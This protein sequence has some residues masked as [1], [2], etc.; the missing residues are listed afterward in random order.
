MTGTYFHFV[1]SKTESMALGQQTFKGKRHTEQDTGQ[2]GEHTSIL[3][4]SEDYK[5]KWWIVE[6]LSGA[7]N[8]HNHWGTMACFIVREILGLSFLSD[9]DFPVNRSSLMVLFLDMR[10]KELYT[11]NNQFVLTQCG[12]TF[13]PNF[14]FG[15]ISLVLFHSKNCLLNR[16]INSSK[17]G[18]YLLLQHFL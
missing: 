8:F 4:R 10:M 12:L 18:V 2:C 17:G 13:F 5:E 7:Y 1:F 15:W 9:P 11:L 6:I 16:V 14:H 3:S